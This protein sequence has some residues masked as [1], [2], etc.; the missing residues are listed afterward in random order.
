MLSNIHRLFSHQISGPIGRHYKV[1]IICVGCIRSS[2]KINSSAV[3][4]VKCSEDVLAEVVRVP[5]KDEH[6]DHQC[7][8]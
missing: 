6:H 7:C 8:R 2:P 5:A 4:G 3:V 1:I